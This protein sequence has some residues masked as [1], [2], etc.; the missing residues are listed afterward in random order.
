MVHPTTLQAL[1]HP[2]SLVHLSNKCRLLTISS[3]LVTSVHSTV[4]T[5]RRIPTEFCNDEVVQPAAL[6]KAAA[7]RGPQQALKA[8]ASREPPATRKAATAREIPAT[9]KAA[10]VRE[11]LATRKAATAREIPATRKAATARETPATRKA[12]TVRE[13]PATRKAATTHDA[14]VARKAATALNPVLPLLLEAASRR[15][16]V[17]GRSREATGPC[18][19]I[20][21]SKPNHSSI[22]LLRKSRSHR[23]AGRRKGGKKSS[24]L[25][26][27]PSQ[28]EIR[29]AGA[30]E[31]VQQII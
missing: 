29:F 23:G 4:K 27:K 18:R 17:V 21:A 2:K 26:T 31:V 12:A 5:N 13:T 8:A 1:V 9:R 7:S 24:I 11:P 19:P 30:S 28:L 14:P 20:D 22:G 15:L 10:T 6:V 25:L 3:Q 16:S